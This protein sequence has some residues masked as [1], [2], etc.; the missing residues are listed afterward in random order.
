MNCIRNV[1]SAS[2]IHTRTYTPFGE[3][4]ISFSIRVVKLPLMTP[5]CTRIECFGSTKKS[6]K[7]ALHWPHER[8]NGRHTELNVRE[9][10]D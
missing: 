7:P 3:S 10:N 2:T 5:A 9:C 8:N 4:S 6:P 1:K